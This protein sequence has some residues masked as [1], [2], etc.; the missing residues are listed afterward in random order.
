MTTSTTLTA[1]LI[2]VL[3]ISGVLALGNYGVKYY[4]ETST[5]GDGNNLLDNYGNRSSSTLN[6]FGVDDLPDTESSVSAETGNVFTDLFRTAKNW[7]LDTKGAKYV[8]GVIGAPVIL[9][10]SMGLDP[11]IV[12]I[13]GAMG[14]GFFAFL[15]ISWLFNR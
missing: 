1:G 12:W 14:Y 3:V 5:F 4:D 11:V 13:I 9:L 10:T 6:E 15:I 7:V 2:L 8:T